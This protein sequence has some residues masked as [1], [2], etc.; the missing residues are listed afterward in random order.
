M[1]A[2]PGE[3]LGAPRRCGAGGGWPA[4]VRVGVGRPG[5]GAGGRRWSWVRWCGRAVAGRLWCGLAAVALGAVVLGAM[6][7][8]AMVLGAGGCPGPG[9]VAADRRL[10]EGAGALA[11]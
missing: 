1:A 8:D 7:L 5:C 11:V 10:P 3:G 9:A 4:V 6:V 2:G